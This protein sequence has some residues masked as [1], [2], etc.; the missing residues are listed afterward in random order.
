MKVCRCPD[1]MDSLDAGQEEAVHERE[2][3]Q[4]LQRK[5]FWKFAT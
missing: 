1:G 5:S 4:C 3:Q 2:W